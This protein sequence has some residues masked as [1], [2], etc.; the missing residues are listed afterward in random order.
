MNWRSD[1]KEFICL[2]IPAVLGFLMVYNI[3][4]TIDKRNNWFKKFMVY[5]GENTLCIYVFHIVSFKLVSLIKIWYY[6][7]DYLQI[8]CHMVIH[9]HAKEDLFWILY[10]IV[11]V[12]IPLIWNYYYHKIKKDLALSHS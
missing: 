7:L 5:C 12:G 2:P 1:F 4:A 10:S 8:G 11:G 6:N 9:E 3:S